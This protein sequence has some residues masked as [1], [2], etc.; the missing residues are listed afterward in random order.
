METTMPK[1]DVITPPGRQA[2]YD[3]HRYSLRTVELSNGG[4]LQEIDLEDARIEDS[5]NEC[6]SQREN[7]IRPRCLDSSLRECLYVIV[8][9]LIASSLSVLQRTTVILATSLQTA[10]DAST[11]EVIWTTAAPG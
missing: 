4:P 9:A 3:M 10:L 1:R 2:L 7:P 11:P 8:S 6:E 5:I